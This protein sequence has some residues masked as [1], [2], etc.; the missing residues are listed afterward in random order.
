M[1]RTLRRSLIVLTAVGLLLLGASSAFA[2]DHGVPFKANYSGAS[3]FTS[4]TTTGFAGSGNASH[5]GNVSATGQAQILCFP[6]DA[7]SQSCVGSAGCPG[8]VPNINTQTLAAANGDTLTIQSN[9]VACP[10]GPNQYRG[11]GQWTVVGGTGRFRG[12]TGNGSFAG[13]SDFGAGTFDISLNGTI[14]Y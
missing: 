12:A 6:P 9:D 2:R 10:T 14:D 3:A 1:N 4:Q 11:A 13:H 5:M 8:G 7:T